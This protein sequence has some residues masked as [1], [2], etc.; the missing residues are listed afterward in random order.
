MKKLNARP[1]L[2]FAEALA[3]A[4]GI[5]LLIRPENGLALI[6]GIAPSDAMQGAGRIAAAA[7]LA[8]GVAGWPGM[9]GT[10]VRLNSIRAMQVFSAI[11]AIVLAYQGI[12]HDV[13]GPVLWPLVALH[14]LLAAALA[15]SGNP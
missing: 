7:M 13:A 8:L 9:P 1:V 6:F 3:I 12:A 5:L 14:A 4:M 15:V 11:L 2:L 10:R